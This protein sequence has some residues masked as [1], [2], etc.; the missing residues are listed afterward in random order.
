[1]LQFNIGWEDTLEWILKMR[2]IGTK[3]ITLATDQPRFKINSEILGGSDTE[4]RTEWVLET[5]MAP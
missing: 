2:F 3:L 1:M 4:P 5:R